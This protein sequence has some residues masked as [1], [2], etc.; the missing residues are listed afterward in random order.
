MSQGHTTHLSCAGFQH[1][2]CHCCK[3]SDTQL[4]DDL[5]ECV[6]SQEQVT[7]KKTQ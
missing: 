5:I 7:S 4:D 1:E 2:L 6:G 3:E